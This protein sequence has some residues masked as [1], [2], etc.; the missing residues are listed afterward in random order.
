VRSALIDAGVELARSGGPDALVLREVTRMVGV[1]P[2][3]AYRHFAD[4]DA[5]LAAVR[6]A[7]V[8]QLARRMADGMSKVRAGPHTP[9]GAR[10]RLTAV[11][12]AYLE[13][14]RT[15]PG[16][17]DTAFTA[18]DHLPSV[19]ADEP[20]PLEYLQAALDDLVQA[21]VLDPSRRPNI[22]YPTWA[23][24]HGLAVLLRGPLHSLPDREKTQ[25]ETQ[26]LAFIGESLS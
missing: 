8:T 23:A 1:V 2:N 16:L 17:F 26:M 25:L 22:E 15:E 9:T 11:G 5:L 14:A 4:R 7:A 12:R 18:T 24:V 19:S 10:L 20:R 6:D 3:A 13:F 21:G